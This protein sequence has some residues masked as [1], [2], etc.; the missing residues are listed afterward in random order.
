VRYHHNQ[1]FPSLDLVGGYGLRGVENSFEDAAGEIGDGRHPAY[2]YGIVLT[3]P[4]GNRTA[5]NNY[6]ASLTEKKQVELVV[7]KLE[8]NVLAQVDNAIKLARSAFRRIKSTRQA[9][10][11]AEAALEAE[12]KKMRNGVSTSFIVLEYLQKLGD[13]RTAEMRALAD[14]K[15]ALAQLAL[16]EGNALEKNQLSLEIR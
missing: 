3:V 10:E 5:R 13:A 8:Q 1:L 16:N 9:R 7:K 14:Y 15:K 6:Q 4:L 12:Q 11:F 2:S